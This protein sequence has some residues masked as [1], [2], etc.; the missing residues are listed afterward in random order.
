LLVQKT[1]VIV[2]WRVYKVTFTKPIDHELV[3]EINVSD[4]DGKRQADIE[5]L[6]L[7][8]KEGWIKS[9]L[10]DFHTQRQAL[11]RFFLGAM[12]LSDPVLNVI[13]RELKRVSPDVRI[14]VQQIRDV[15]SSEVI[16]R[17]VMEGEK[18]EEARKKISRAAS[19]ALRVRAS[20]DQATQ[21][22]APETETPGTPPA[23]PAAAPP[24]PHPTAKA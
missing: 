21:E 2:C 20:K 1:V 6:Y 7:L 10:G 18:A 12:V 22:S 24:T 17:D 23:P 4:L 3:V 15:L 16:K 11:S 14:E 8:C 5:S 13:R 9:V 19:K